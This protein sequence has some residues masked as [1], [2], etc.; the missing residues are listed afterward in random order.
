MNLLLNLVE[1]PCLRLSP[2]QWPRFNLNTPPV[3]G[4]RL[5]LFPQGVEDTWKAH[6]QGA[7]SKCLGTLEIAQPCALSWCHPWQPE[8]K[9][10]L[11]RVVQ[12]WVDDTR[13]WWDTRLRLKVQCL[14]QLQQA[15]S[16]VNWSV[17]FRMCWKD[18]QPPNWV[19]LYL[20]IATAKFARVML[21][22]LRRSSSCEIR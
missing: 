16:L 6:N 8:V 19:H 11:E 15:T 5:T 13:N 3:R 10:W 2:G 4:R 18:V 12:N 20:L 14:T 22:G 17:N 1:K 7:G 21:P 9:P